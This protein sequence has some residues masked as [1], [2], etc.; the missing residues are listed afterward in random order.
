MSMLK[1]SLKNTGIGLA[2]ALL[3]V[4]GAALGIHCSSDASGA[5]AQRG[6]YVSDD[7]DA[8]DRN[9]DSVRRLV[10]RNPLRYPV[11]VEV[12]CRQDPRT[13]TEAAV[14]PRRPTT[15][16]MASD[17]PLAAGDCGIYRWHR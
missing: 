5:Q 13:V 1:N 2:L 8:G 10:V 4:A 3:F 16:E 9:G 14:A 7:V 12:W 11:S 6:P 17:R 15:F